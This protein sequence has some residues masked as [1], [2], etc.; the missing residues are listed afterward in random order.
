[1]TQEERRAQEEHRRVR[2][3][4]IES[5]AKR[6]FYD[7]RRLAGKRR[8]EWDPRKHISWLAA[9]RQSFISG[10]IRLPVVEEGKSEVAPT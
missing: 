6:L 8:V 2:D 3:E 7:Q 5:I 4:Q 9:V 1:M 10:L